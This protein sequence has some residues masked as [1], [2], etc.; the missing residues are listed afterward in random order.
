[1]LLLPWKSVAYL[2]PNFKQ[3]VCV[4]LFKSFEITFIIHFQVVLGLPQSSEY[5]TW[6][7]AASFGSG[8]SRKPA[9]RCLSGCGRTA[10]GI[11]RRHLAFPSPTEQPLLASACFCL[12]ASSFSGK[13]GISWARCIFPS[14]LSPAARHDSP[15]QPLA[16]R[17][18]RAAARPL[19]PAGTPRSLSTSTSIAMWIWPRNWHRL[20]L[21]VN[22]QM[23]L[24][25]SEPV[26]VDGSS[27]IENW[28]GV[29]KC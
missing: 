28:F 20:S 11:C 10:E 18:G 7:P 12:G 4:W 5:V 22:V 1:M 9:A 14:S 3:Q 16:Q 15:P 27:W 29:G 25:L 17:W 26:P 8:G 24:Q 21:R 19:L 6:K 23:L 2:E 13:L